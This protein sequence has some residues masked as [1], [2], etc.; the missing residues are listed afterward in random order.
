MAAISHIDGLSIQPDAQIFASIGDFEL[1]GRYAGAT[2]SE[3]LRAICPICLV[4]RDNRAKFTFSATRFGGYSP[5]TA[6]RG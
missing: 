1:D 6:Q 3:K 5:S 2:E 4:R